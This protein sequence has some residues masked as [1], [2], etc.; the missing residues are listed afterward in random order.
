VPAVNVPQEEISGTVKHMVDA[1]DLEIEAIRE[2]GFSSSIW[3]DGKLEEIVAYNEFDALTTY[4]VWLRVAHFGG[5]FTHK[6]YEVEEQL[7]REL[8][9]S[10]IESGK[11]HL[12]KYLEEW[13]RLK[14]KTK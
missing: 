12:N 13:N 2:K 9:L 5:H 3:L 14:A 6:E 1:L 11:I 7:V 4:L 8:I 10:E